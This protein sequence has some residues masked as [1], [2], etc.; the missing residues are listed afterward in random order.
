MSIFL[1]SLLDLDQPRRSLYVEEELPTP[2]G[3]SI[4]DA[5]LQARESPR[6]Q[7][8][9]AEVLAIDGAVDPFATPLHA[10]EG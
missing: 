7:A 6:A 3:A 10:R 5:D 8:D 4:V 9:D 1:D 2:V